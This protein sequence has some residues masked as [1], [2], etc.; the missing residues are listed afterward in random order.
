[1]RQRDERD[2]TRAHA[3]MLPAP[4]AVTID[5]SDLTIAQVVDLLVRR[6]R[7]S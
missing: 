4:D 2:R 5:T 7:G 1:L 3:P 6:I